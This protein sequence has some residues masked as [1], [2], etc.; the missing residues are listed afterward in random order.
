MKRWLAVV[1][2][3]GAL[4][5]ACGEQPTQQQNEALYEANNVYSHTMEQLELS[6]KHY[7]IT[8]LTSLSAEQQQNGI[9]ENTIILEARL[10]LTNT[11]A[12]AV[13]YA[14]NVMLIVGGQQLVNEAERLALAGPITSTEIAPNEQQH[15][16]IAFEIPESLYEQHSVATLQLPT[17]FTV[18]GSTSSGDALGDNGE[19]KIPLK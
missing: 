15:F 2:V 16:T 19:W 13:Y 1:L 18:S 4:L 7:S 14:P 3:A 5:S 8:K 10:T 11:L 12:S 9:E 17:A 6:M